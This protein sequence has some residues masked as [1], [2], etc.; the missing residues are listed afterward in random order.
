MQEAK[1]EITTL[2]SRC[3]PL[4]TFFQLLTAWVSGRLDVRGQGSQEV[5]GGQ[6]TETGFVASG[7]TA[8]D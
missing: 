1:D 8:G 3:C 2:G 4:A 6:R 7:G 5:Q